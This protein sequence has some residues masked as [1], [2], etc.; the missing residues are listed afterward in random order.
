[1][2]SLRIGASKRGQSGYSDYIYREWAGNI[3]AESGTGGGSLR[4]GYVRS[5]RSKLQRFG[6]STSED[7]VTWVVFMHLLPVGAA[8]FGLEEVGRISTTCPLRSHRCCV[9]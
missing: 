5:R 9:G 2:R 6:F 8:C 4:N 7:A 3:P 1:M